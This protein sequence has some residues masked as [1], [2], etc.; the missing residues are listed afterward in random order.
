[1]PV[2]ALVSFP[3]HGGVLAALGLALVVTK[4]GNC[5]G[6]SE[7]RFLVAGSSQSVGIYFW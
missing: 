3:S 5:Q 2:C 4:H 7:K 6:G 1:M